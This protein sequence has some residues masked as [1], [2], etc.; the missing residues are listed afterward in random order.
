MTRD[1]ERDRIDKIDE[2]CSTLLLFSDSTSTLR[3]L[4]N[5]SIYSLY[6]GP[7]NVKYRNLDQFKSTNN[8][9]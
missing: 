2:R 1:S 5:P 4:H 9:L 6:T 3:G 7:E 8:L